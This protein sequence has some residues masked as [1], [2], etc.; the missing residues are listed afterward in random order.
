MRTQHLPQRR[1]KQVRRRVV[2]HRVRPMLRVDARRH[3][4]SNHD[5]SLNDLA[6]IHDPPCLPPPLPVVHDHSPA[7]PDNLTTVPDLASPLWVERCHIQEDLY[8]VSLRSFLDRS[9]DISS[10]AST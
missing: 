1:V 5:S 4:I 10:L 2:S 3:F 6:P 7:R 9:A 8:L